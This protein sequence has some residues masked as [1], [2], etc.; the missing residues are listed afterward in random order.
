MRVHF[1]PCLDSEKVL[2]IAQYLPATYAELDRRAKWMRGKWPK[3]VTCMSNAEIV[4]GRARGA[5]HGFTYTSGS[6]SGTIWLNP[7]MT[8]Q[9]YWLVLVHENC[10]HAW[11]DATEGEINCRHV[12]SIYEAVFGKRLTPA[13]GRAHG[14]GA[15]VPGVGDRSYCR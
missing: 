3:R 11:P 7:D 4:D 9:G 14:L 10:H 1:A 15:P 12:P 2:K 5:G 13:M 8:W 6:N